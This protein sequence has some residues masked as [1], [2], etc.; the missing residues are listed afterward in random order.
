MADK[1]C[2]ET[3]II[4]WIVDQ[5]TIISLGGLHFINI[6]TVLQ[7]EDPCIP[8]YDAWCG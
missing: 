7:Y 3:V 6:F 1:N 2:K 8:T 4:C 5:M